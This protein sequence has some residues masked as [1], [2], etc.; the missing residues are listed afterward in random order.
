MALATLTID[1]VAKLASL[2]RDMG[3]AAQ[4]AERNA[5]RMDEAFSRVKTSLAAIGSVLTVGAFAGMVRSVA[6]AGDQLQ[7]LSTKTGATV[8]ELSKLQYAASL[9]DLSNEDLGASLVKLNKV[10]G[11]VADGSK[12]ATEALARFGIAPESGLST[13]EALRQIAD[14]VKATGDETKIASAL[15][16]V[17][18]K[19]FATLIPLLKG[20]SEGL[21]DAGDELERMGGVM[22][23]ELAEASERFNDN[24]TRIGAS[25]EALKVRSLGPVVEGLDSLTS[26][27]NEAAKAAGG[28]WS[29]LATWATTG[30][31]QESNP[32]GAIVEITKKLNT[33]KETKAGLEAPTLA[34]RLGFNTEDIAIVNK[35][36]DVLTTQLKYLQNLNT[37][38]VG[39]IKD[40][41]LSKAPSFDGIA[42]TPPSTPKPKR[43]GGTKL[44]ATKADDELGAFL[45]D[46]KSRLDPAEQALESFRKVQLD[47]AVAGADLTSAEKQFYDLINSD[48]WKTMSEPWRE[49]VRAQFESANAAEIA[50]SEQEKLNSLISGTPTAKLQEA[51]DKLNFLADAYNAAKITAV[52]LDEA[53]QAVL[54]TIQD[55]AKEAT[56]SMST[57]ADQAARNM[58]D[59]FADF[60]FDP[61]EDGVGGM[62]KGFGEALRRMIAEAVAADLAS[63]VF[64]KAG[65]GEGSGLLGAGLDWLSGV[66]KN[67]DGGVYMSPGLSAYS[68][69][70]VSHPTVFP[71]A[72]G[73]GLMGEAGPEAILPLKRG[74]DGKLGVSAGG[75]GGHTINVYVSGTNA[76][77]VR[78]AAGQGAREALS[79]INGA[80]RYR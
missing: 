49:L 10:M 7:K 32:A 26:K 72:R 44:K 22:S 39:N 17:F 54:A 76:P 20:G 14:K 51:A 24:L 55:N 8:E 46:L 19:S 15:N 29:G 38:S 77:D 36:I 4:I 59:A 73:I 27:F 66:L 47:A 33:L 58:Q 65:G 69:Q 78:R 30:G 11:E 43:V 63:K 18:G 71:F 56:D 25:L 48:D 80:G 64:G 13:V 42:D 1:L 37:A 57:F 35:Q 9:S 62:L 74:A 21:K 67:A 41:W 52:Q 23:G 75:G 53:S 6:D 79:A 28:F 3:K 45:D 2:E 5:K 70:V 40:S 50:A 12:T 34:N 31:D 60:L 68:G 16:D 61:F